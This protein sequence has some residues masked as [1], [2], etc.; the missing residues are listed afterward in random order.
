MANNAM[1]TPLRQSVYISR[2]LSYLDEIAPERADY[3]EA[4][5]ESDNELCPSCQLKTQGA[6][7]PNHNDLVNNSD[8]ADAASNARQQRNSSPILA[9]PSDDTNVGNPIH[10]S[11]FSNT[12]SGGAQELS[13]CGRQRCH[14]VESRTQSFKEIRFG[15][16]TTDITEGRAK[17]SNTSG[18]TSK[19]RRRKARK[20][21][22]K[23]SNSNRE[24]ILTR[25]LRKVS[26]HRDK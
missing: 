2:T 25:K 3:F 19:K 17:M 16:A 7:L 6:T 13:D 18:G 9:Q 23:G 10:E 4:A 24:F 12:S 26:L 11:E 21:V 8:I 5:L 20:P 1:E 15:A 14:I 22:G